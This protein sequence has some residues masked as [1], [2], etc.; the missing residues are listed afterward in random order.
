MPSIKTNK[1]KV[2]QYVTT[3]FQTQMSR[4]EALSTEIEVLKKEQSLYRQCNAIGTSYVSKLIKSLRDT[5]KQLETEVMD[6]I[7]E[8][9]SLCL[10]GL[11]AFDQSQ[12]HSDFALFVSMLRQQYPALQSILEI[13]SR[14]IEKNSWSTLTPRGN[15]ILELDHKTFCEEINSLI[16][17]NKQECDELMRK[18]VQTL[19]ERDIIETKS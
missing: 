8:P 9:L 15:S 7:T 16:A 13:S 19:D 14:L 1:E 6:R 18:K 12:D 5:H 11:R 4:M 10:T 2:I 3:V 17:S